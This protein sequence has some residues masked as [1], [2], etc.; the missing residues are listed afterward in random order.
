MK[1]LPIS[2]VYLVLFLFFFFNLERLDI[3]QEN[4]INLDSFVYFL[5]TAVILSIILVPPIRKQSFTTL[6]ILGGILYLLCKLLFSRQE[7]MLGGLNTY[8]SIAEITLLTI[9]IA[10][11]NKIA[12]ELDDFVKA[13]ENITFAEFERVKTFSEGF[14]YARTEIYRSRRFQHPLTII[15]VEPQ[16]ETLDVLLHRTVVDVLRSMMMRYVS[17]SKIGRAHV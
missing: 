3:Y 14:E 15:L 12:K 9:S 5:V 11:A 4:V 6:A 10:L 2:I 7:F 16:S 8:I 17:V 1:R 13:V